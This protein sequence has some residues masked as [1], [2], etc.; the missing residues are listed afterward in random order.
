[1]IN[2]I[3]EFFLNQSGGKSSLLDEFES[4][5]LSSQDFVRKTIY[6]MIRSDATEDLVQETYL[7][8]WRNFKN[9]RSESSFQTWIY[10]IARNCVFDYLKKNPIY[11]EFNEESSINTSHELELKDTI[12]LGL[13]TLSPKHREVFILFYKFEYTQSEIAELLSEKE[14]TIKSRIHYAK[15]TF[16]K[17]IAQHDRYDCDSQKGDSHEG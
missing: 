8:A 4:H 3:T 17:T 10:R 6:W 9:F 7:K 15:S 5:Y 1:M 13:Q 16:E 11:V 2:S 12:Q 14:G